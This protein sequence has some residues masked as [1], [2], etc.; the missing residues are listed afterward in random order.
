MG[1]AISVQLYSCRQFLDD[2]DATLGALA[3]IGL[4]NVEAFNYVSSPEAL[5]AALAKHGL[6]APTGH[7]PLMSDEMRTIEAVVSV[8]SQDVVLDA[9]RRAGVAWVIDPMTQADRWTT[10][11]GIQDLAA[12]LNSAAAKAAELGLSVG[13]HNHSQEIVPRFD[14]R[15][16]L[17]VFADL[18]D[19]NVRLEVDVFWAAVGGVDPVDLLHKLGSRVGALHVKNTTHDV[20][21]MEMRAAGAL[22]QAPAGSGNL[23][24]QA[25]IEAAPSAEYV[26]IEFDT[27][28]GDIFDG[29]KASYD[30]LRSLG[31]E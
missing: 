6:A 26:V 2:L 15:T 17:E 23:D 13:Y 27:Y 1:P 21:G 31:L 16:A 5:A 4:K 12:R 25:I 3:A 30:H 8:P 14:G 19:E 22:P 24:M 29:I 20:A 7:A 10:L 28:D 9:S 18:L 11:D